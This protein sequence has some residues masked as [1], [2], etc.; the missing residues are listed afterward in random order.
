M[1]LCHIVPSLEARHGGPSKSV[2][3]LASAFAS[4]GPRIELL[5]TDPAGP[6]EHTEGDLTVR[7]FQRHR[8]G[9][10]RSSG[11]LRRYLKGAAADIVHHHALWL[12]TLHYAHRAARRSGAP[13]VVSPRGMMDP[14]AWGHHA[15]RKALAR[16]LVHPGAFEAV[17]GWHATSE[18]EAENIRQLGFRQPVCVAPNGISVPS[19]EDVSR[20]AALWYGLLPAARSHPVA[21]FYSRFHRK[22]RVIELIDLWIDSGPRDWLLLMVGIP[23]EYTAS[24]LET[25]VLRRGAPGRIRVFDGTGLPSPYSIA[26]LFLLPSQGE[27]F[28]LS[29][30]EALASSVPAIVTDSTPW[31][32]L[33][34]TGGGWCVPW[35][36]FGRTLQSAAAEPAESLSHRGRIARE[37]VVHEYSWEKSARALL[38]FYS[39]LVSKGA[40]RRP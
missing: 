22:K 3:G 13:L 17:D 14:W 19:P 30:A 36:D 25:Y 32:A 12:R 8:P 34:S 37:W 39:H 21:L 5:T 18:K 27:N 4:L 20:D 2:P 33:Q 24:E 1:K 15:R 40:G 26:S 9:L 35:D 31:A 10:L 6:W 28:G 29:I 38:G 16:A 7:A 23:E 11:G